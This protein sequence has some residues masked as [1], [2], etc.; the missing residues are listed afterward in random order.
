[1]QEEEDDEEEVVLRYLRRKQQDVS[2]EWLEYSVSV[3]GGGG[4]YLTVELQQE[5]NVRTDS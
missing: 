5:V 1:M 4:C 3:E 2:V